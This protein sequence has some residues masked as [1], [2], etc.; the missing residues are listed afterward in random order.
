MTALDTL[1][2]IATFG[3]YRRPTEARAAQ[4]GGM[5]FPTYQIAKPVYPDRTINTYADEGLRKLALIFRCVSL[6]ATSTGA[7]PIKVY[8]ED[9][10]GNQTVLPRHPMRMLMKRPNP[11]MG[12][13]R[14]VAYVAMV[15]SVA[16]FCLV[17]KERSAAGRVVGLYPL[18]SDWAFPIPR[19][20]APPDWEYRI[21][22][23][24][25]EV[26]LAED[27]LHFT[28]ADR[29][30]GSPF[31][32][33]ALEVALRETSILNEMV[34]FLMAFFQFGA[35]PQVGLVPNDGLMQSS[36]KQEDV[37]LIKETWRR[38]YGGLRNSV[39]PAI[40]VGIKDI[41]RLSFDFNELAYTDLRDLSDLA[42]CQAF[43]VPPGL[44]GA[45]IGLER[46]TFSNAAEMRKSFYEDTIS[47]LWTR[48]DDVFTIDLLPEFESNPNV[49]M[50]FDT[51]KIAALQEN[52]NDKAAWLNPV[53]LG[54][55]IP[56]SI[57]YA[58]MGLGK[59]IQDFYL[60]GFT[61]DAIPAADPLGLK[62]KPRAT[63]QP[64]MLPATT[65]DD[66]DDEPDDEDEERARVVVREYRQTIRWVGH[67][68]RYVQGLAGVKNPEIRWHRV[69]GGPSPSEFRAS[70]A[71]LNR[72][73]VQRIAETVVLWLRRFFGDQ[74]A[75][76]VNGIDFNHP[77][78]LAI[79]WDAETEALG[80]TVHRIYALA[81]D[82][83]YG[84]IRDAYGITGISFDLANPNLAD[85]RDLLAQRVTGITD[86]SR[87][88]IQSVVT[89]A[90]TEGVTVDEL[91]SRLSTQFET[92]S[93]SRAETIARTE[94]QVA[95]N[96]ASV[97]GYRESGV[98]DRVM[99]HD[100]ESHTEDYGAS[101]GLSCAAR[102]GRVVPL[103]QAQIHINAEHPRGT[104]AV[105]GVLTGEEV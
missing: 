33:G 105:S 13:S 19:R 1:L 91:A 42:I 36:F 90:L 83:A 34:D 44:V 7:A 62:L 37:A 46:N 39:D 98:V 82:V 12:E 2:S 26:I 23:L 53:F 101:D 55:G 8:S 73:A 48:L 64:P 104:L 102:N 52:R 66:E 58:E 54:G 30:D 88:V 25:P 71:V 31:G 76:I 97:H 65:G 94:S 49:D 11:R 24:R 22:G 81:G 70:V 14:F 21:P 41:K 29:P 87:R 16:G 78:A 93:D 17:E 72:R 9:Q 15:A 40:L 99:L 60:R 5:A 86:E 57:Y 4:F 45:R 56:A 47:P 6:V 63:V 32:L 61:Q 10:E 28:Y 75:R 79:D 74:E 80:A 95:F 69:S 59:P 77:D 92:W 3:A 18:R 103:S 85:V 100:N 51:S 50:A 38:R 67:D 43:G 20:N 27:V 35:M 96:S 68:D 84:Q 89:D